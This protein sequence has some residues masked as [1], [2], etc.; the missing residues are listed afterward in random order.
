VRDFI[1]IGGES[2]GDSVD[3]AYDRYVFDEVLNQEATQSMVFERTAKPLLP[4]VLEGYNA[5]IFAYGVSPFMSSFGS[6][7][8]DRQL[9]V[10]RHTPSVVKKGTKGSLF[11][12]WNTSTTNSR[13]TRKRT[14]ITSNY[15]LS[16]STTKQPKIFSRI[17]TQ[18]GPVK[19]CRY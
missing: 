14:I 1:R 7:L 8:M 10:E 9:D 5:T 4:G 18:N 6:V 19:A 15:L 11:D 12:P 3:C 13:K 2:P 17:Q 16:K